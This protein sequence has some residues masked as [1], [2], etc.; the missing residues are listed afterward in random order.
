[1]EKEKEEDAY[2]YEYTYSESSRS[3]SSEDYLIQK[4]TDQSLESTLSKIKRHLA[5]RKADKEKGAR[6]KLLATAAAAGVTKKKKDKADKNAVVTEREQKKGPDVEEARPTRK[7]ESPLKRSRS[8][9]KK[10][11]CGDGE[12]NKERTAR[13]KTKESEARPDRKTIPGGRQRRCPTCE[14]KGSSYNT[15]ILF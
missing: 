1:M 12:S 4:M 11:R 10:Q 14:S 5:K 7:K 8:R 13:T 2:T 3:P 6:K 9:K 15:S